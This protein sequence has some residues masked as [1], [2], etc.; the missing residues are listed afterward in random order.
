M[1]KFARFIF[2][3]FC[4]CK[5]NYQV[6]YRAVLV[7]IRKWVFPKK[8]IQCWSYHAVRQT[9]DKAKVDCKLSRKA[10]VEN[11]ILFWETV[12]NS[13]PGK[14]S[15]Y[16]TNCSPTGPIVLS[17]WQIMLINLWSQSRL[18][19]SLSYSWWQI[20]LTSTSQ[21]ERIRI[22]YDSKW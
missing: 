21:E 2:L 9:G 1:R 16:S 10:P 4:F 19:I 20:S 18:L 22:H 5:I 14:V 13:I 7:G 3:Q 17:C 6:Y 8:I 11:K 12:K 15:R